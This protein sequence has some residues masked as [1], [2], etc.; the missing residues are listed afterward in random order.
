M[1]DKNSIL[2]KN[3]LSKIIA[4]L[5]VFIYIFISI[6]PVFAIAQTRTSN[7]DSIDENL[8]PGYKTLL[9]SLQ[10]THPNWTFTLLY[11][12]LDWSQVLKNETIVRHT[13]SLVQNHTGEWLCTVCG[14]TRYDNGS[15]C[16]ASEKAVAYYMDPRNFLTEENI[17]Q[18]ET[19]SF[20]KDNQ[21][22]N[23]VNKII[24]GTFMQGEKIKYLDSEGKEQILEKSYAQVIM[25]AG[26]KYNVSPYH[27]ASRI[28]QEQG[29]RGSST[30]SGTVEN[31]KGYYNI[32][33]IRA[34]GNS[35]SV[36]IANALN[37]AKEKGWD[38]P[39]KAILGGAEFLVRGYIASGQDTLYLQKF[40]V[41][42]SDGSLYTY[43]YMQNIVAPLNE[44]KTMYKSY[45]ELDL[46]NGNLN[47]VIPLYKNMPAEVSQYPK[48]NTICTEN[49]KVI[50]TNIN[51]RAGN[52][53]GTSSIAKVNKDDILLRI[54]IS[55]RKE[56]GYFWDKVV[57]SNGSIGYIARYFIEK[58]NDITNCEKTVFTTTTVNVRN[59][60]GTENTT[61]ITTISAGQSVTVIEDKGYNK[62][63]GLWQRVRLADG[64]QGY[65]N[66][67]YL[68]ESSL[69]NREQVIVI[70]NGSLNV[71]SAP[72]GSWLSSVPQGTTIT[73]L[74]KGIEIIAGYCWDKVITPDGVEGYVATDYLK[75]VSEEKPE[76]KPEEK[77][78]EKEQVDFKL[79]ETKKQI[80]MEPNTTLEDIKN[81]TTGKTITA[82]D[83]SGK[84]VANTVSLGTG[85]KVT[86]DKTSYTIIKKGDLNG[87]GLVDVIDLALIKRHLLKTNLLK[88][89]YLISGIL[90][91]NKTEIDVIDLA[92]M[93]RQLLKTQKISL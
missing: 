26:E 61:V 12:D 78:V 46:L 29:A 27:L 55:A 30:A 5:L 39:E 25:E 84:L 88:D 9:K 66:S 54:E 68:S 53:T 42:N 19:L 24:A 56:N 67:K 89:V 38:N 90:Q 64:R 47:F 71:R 74:E 18:F 33:N 91:K 37:Y 3:A 13:R 36:I 62:T 50:D 43:Q 82:V 73:R 92:L 45:K 2:S 76:Q 41:D 81:K 59:G 51:V 32:F 14:N 16:C 40:D 8:Y 34:T 70:A 75:I 87:D 60:P 77:P 22:I 44:G 79:E 4:S 21:T 49:V 35:S 69:E 10:Q 48:D 57:L 1:L 93:Q 72:N 15:W 65:M 23:G 31:H 7:I 28:K 86:I 83:K 20:S 11:T 63:D 52:S 6:Q 85:S 17:F 80:I 58:I